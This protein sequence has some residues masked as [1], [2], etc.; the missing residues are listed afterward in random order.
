MSVGLE[1][2][3]KSPLTTFCITITTLCPRSDI[4]HLQK[5]C[6]PGY[7]CVNVH[8]ILGQSCFAIYACMH[9]TYNIAMLKAS[10]NTMLQYHDNACIML[11]VTCVNDAVP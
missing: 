11:S 5:M 7:S 1:S 10:V 4:Q 3:T 2:L 9:G 8:I 6:L